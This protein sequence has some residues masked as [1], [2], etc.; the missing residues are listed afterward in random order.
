MCANRIDE[1]IAC[2]CGYIYILCVC[3]ICKWSG[4]RG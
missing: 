4:A 1:F 2:V 3:V